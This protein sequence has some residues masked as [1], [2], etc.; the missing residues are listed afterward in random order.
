MLRHLLEV[1]M[2]IPSARKGCTVIL[3]EGSR[4]HVDR[5]TSETIYYRCAKKGCGGRGKKSKNQDFVLTKQHSQH[6]KEDDD[7]AL[8]RDSAV[9]K[10]IVSLLMGLA[11][12]PNHNIEEGHKCIEIYARQKGEYRGAVR[13]LLQYCKKFWLEKI[14]ADSISVFGLKY[15]TNN[16]MERFHL[17][18]LGYFEAPHP[19][20]WVFVDLQ[21]LENNEAVVRSRKRRYLLND[22]RIQRANKHLLDGDYDVR[23]FLNA[24]SH[25]TYDPLRHEGLRVAEESDDDVQNRPI[26]IPLRRLQ[27]RQLPAR[28]QPPTGNQEVHEDFTCI[29]CVTNERQTINLPYYMLT[30]EPPEMQHEL[31][32]DNK[33]IAEQL[34]QNL[35]K[36]ATHPIPARLAKREIRQ[37]EDEDDKRAVFS[38]SKMQPQL[39]LRYNFV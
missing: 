23:R 19:N 36:L 6:E 1:A 24:V 20:V 16:N 25:C 18:L 14:G 26:R 27:R 9:V 39:D 31:I 12:L 11:L 2:E 28:N 4:F 3:H 38:W 21:R 15:R 32:V 35:A 34:A 22:A 5:T 37:K 30:R 13:A 8:L 33:L 10:K 17:S 29:I 7:L